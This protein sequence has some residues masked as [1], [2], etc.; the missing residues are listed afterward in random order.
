MTSGTSNTSAYIELL[1]TFPPRPINSNEGL[2]ATQK[3]IDSLIGGDELTPDEQDYL[4]VLGT[5]VYEYDFRN[6]KYFNRDF[7]D[8]IVARVESLYCISDLNDLTEKQQI[9]EQIFS[10]NLPIVEEKRTKAACH[11]TRVAF[12]ACSSALAPN[13]ALKR[14]YKPFFNVPAFVSPEKRLS[15]VRMSRGIASASAYINPPLQHLEIG[16]LCYG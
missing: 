14:Y 9:V 7:P 2:L 1:K 12:E 15:R 16:R 3:V 10:K 6:L 4:N 8:E 13:I 5:L 11:I